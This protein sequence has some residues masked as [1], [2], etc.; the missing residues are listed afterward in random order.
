[1]T[2]LSRI[3]KIPYVTLAAVIFA[4][5]SFMTTNAL[6]DDAIISS[7]RPQVQDGRLSFYFQNI[8]IRSLLQIL[9]KSSGLNFVINDAVK[10]S[11]TLNLKNVTWRQAL[12]IILKSHG[13]SYREDGNVIYISTVEELAN[14]ENHQ[15]QAEEQLSNLVPLSSAIFQL[16]YT[17]ATDM[18]TLLKGQQG[19]TLLTSRGQVAVDTRT[20]SI[21]VRDTPKNINEVRR[22]LERLDVPAK[23]VLIEARIVTIDTTYEKQLGVRF[24]VSD[25]RHLS[26]TLNAANQLVG[27][28]SPSQI[29]SGAGGLPDATPRLN[30]NNAATQFASGANPGT[31]GLA[32]GRLGHFLLDLELSALEEN[33][34]VNIISKPRVIA[35]NQQK[36]TIQTGTEIP[37]Q[38]A[39]SSGATSIS[40]KKAVLSLEITP[41]ITPDNKIVLAIKATQDSPGAQIALTAQTTTTP[42][43]LGPPAITTQEVESNVILNDNETIVLGG[44]YKVTKSSTLD[45]VPFLGSLPIVGALFRSKTTNDEKS[46]LLIFI[47]PKIIKS[48]H[49]YPNKVESQYAKDEQ[50]AKHDVYKD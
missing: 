1:M 17:S 48:N 10:G 5:T 40:F 24:G 20:N 12:I 47:T 15:L 50:N 41:Q 42:A 27:G 26:G 23:Q 13:L 16:K 35:S 34:H 25:T 9:A 18:A 28:T 29:I 8:E 33:G 14:N 36:A 4:T 43:T 49:N 32:L 46:E 2:F 31:I 22:A 11:V 19:G 44:I 38:E 6:P 39:T 37:Y 30:F 45:R 3:K 7:L 21:I